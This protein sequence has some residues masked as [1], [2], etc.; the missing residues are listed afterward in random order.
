MKAADWPGVIGELPVD[1]AEA[2]Q[3]PFKEHPQTGTP[4]PLVVTAALRRLRPTG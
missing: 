1:V 2:R 4:R 3:C